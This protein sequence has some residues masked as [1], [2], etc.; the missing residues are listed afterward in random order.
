M[1]FFIY[2]LPNNT[3]ALPLQI[4]HYSDCDMY[5]DDSSVTSTANTRKDVEKRLNANMTSVSEWCT[6]NHIL[7]KASKSKA[8]L[9]TTLAKM[10]FSARTRYMY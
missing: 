10:W 3:N 4:E 9:L 6:N 7:A 5:A 2:G 8:M 1:C